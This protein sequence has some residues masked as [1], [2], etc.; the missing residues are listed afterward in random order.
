MLTQEVK[1]NVEGEVVKEENN[2]TAENP[3]EEQKKTQDVFEEYEVKIEK[4]KENVIFNRKEVQGIVISTKGTP[5]KAYM[6]SYLS[7]KYK[8]PEDHIDMRYIVGKP[9]RKV[10]EFF[11]LIYSRPIK[12]SEDEKKEGSETQ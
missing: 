7:S 2:I 4:E 1:E 12:S 11:A 9:G 8:V 10:F 6:I 3:Q 5:S